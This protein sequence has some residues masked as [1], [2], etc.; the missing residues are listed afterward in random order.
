[1]PQERL[2]MRKIIEIL[3]LKHERKL[4]NRKIAISCGVSKNTVGNYLARAEQAGISWPLPQDISENQ[5]LQLLFPSQEQSYSKE[6]PIPDW[7]VVHR[8]L[9]RKGVTLFLLWE[10]YKQAHPNGYQYSWFCREYRKWRGKLD[11]VMRHT[12]RAGEQIFIDYAGQTVPIVNP[13]TGEVHQAE[14]FVAVMG[15]SNY[16][17]AEAT[18]TQDLWDWINSHVRTFQYLQ[19]VPRIAVPDNLKSGVHKAHI[20]EPDLNPTYQDMARHY[21]L[22]IIPARKRSPRDKAKAETGVQLVTRWILARLRNQTF[23]SL[24]SLN[25]EIRKL[26][27]QLNQKPFKKMEGTRQSLF[28]ELDKPALQ[29]LPA[30]AYEYALWK[31]VR[32]H[33]DYHVEIEKHY[34]SVPHQLVKKQLDARYTENTVEIFHKNQRVASHKR[35]YKKGGY[36]TVKEH[37]PKS[38]KEYAEWTPERLVRW[39]KKSGLNTAELVQ[40]IMSKKIHPQQGFRPCLGIMRLG[41][42]YGYD[43]LDFACKRALYLGSTN[44]K[45]LESI[46]KNNLDKQ[47]LPGETNESDF[48]IPNHEN[49]RGSDYYH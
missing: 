27:Y 2:S 4:S 44:Y 20:Y 43:R 48:Q 1:M 26:L 3:R 37:M 11:L 46:L 14:I 7:N 10:E 19:G 35:S 36:T 5:L 29:P 16:T 17:Y 47:P 6:V 13:D 40:N 21:N 15:A 23:F 49:L 28:E 45:S 18:W 9:Q 8:E 31:K 22:A 41:E 38:H 42:Q 25:W 33:V 24:N 34:Y 30:Q 12:H 39:A 32:V